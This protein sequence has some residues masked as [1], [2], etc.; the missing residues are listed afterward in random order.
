MVPMLSP[1]TWTAVVGLGAV[2]LLIV[3][4]SL[5][6]LWLFVILLALLLVQIRNFYGYSF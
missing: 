3:G 2:G 6:L 5:A 4:H 1:A